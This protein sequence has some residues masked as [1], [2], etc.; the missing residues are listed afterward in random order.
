MWLFD[1]S[2][3][4]GVFPDDWP[5]HPGNNILV[6]YAGGIRPE[7]VRAAIEDKSGRYWIDIETGVRHH[8]DRF[9]IALCRQICQ[10]VYGMVQ[11]A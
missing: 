2:G 4:R 3:G 5:A 11:D 10:S 1:R 6:G 8:D 9:D 7:N